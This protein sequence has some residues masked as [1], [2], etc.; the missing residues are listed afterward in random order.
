MTSCLLTIADGQSAIRKAEQEKGHQKEHITVGRC[1]SRAG[2]LFSPL[3][4][5]KVAWPLEGLLDLG[6]ASSE[7]MDVYFG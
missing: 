5:H 3:H 7:G 1:P 6:R 4:V 2:L